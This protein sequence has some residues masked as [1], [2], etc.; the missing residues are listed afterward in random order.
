M[1]L[2][3]ILMLYVGTMCKWAVLPLFQRNLLPL[4]SGRMKIKIVCVISGSYGGEHKDESLL[5][6]SA[7]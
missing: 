1:S 6:C 7:V 2:L 5:G 3:F 4:S